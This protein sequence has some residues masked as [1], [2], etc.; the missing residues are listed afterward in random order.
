MT[1]RICRLLVVDDDKDVLRSLE[2]MLPTL[3]PE[4][5]TLRMF[6]VSDFDLVSEALDDYRVEIAIVDVKGALNEQI[7]DEHAGERVLQIIRSRR[8]IPVIFYTAVPRWVE[9]HAGPFVKVVA[10]GEIDDLRQAINDILETRLT[11]INLGLFAHIDGLQRD[12]LWKYVEQHWKEMS[13]DTELV[14]QLL[15]RRI[16]AQMSSVALGSALENAGVSNSVAESEYPSEVHPA[17]FYIVPPTYVGLMAGQLYAPAEQNPSAS[18]WTVLLTPTCD[19]VPRGGAGRAAD[20]VLLV[21]AVPPAEMQLRA[22][23]RTNL[24]R[25]NHRDRFYYLPERLELP[26]LAVD[27]ERVLIVPLADSGTWTPV[28]TLDSPFAEELQNR[29]V[30]FFGRIGTPDLDGGYLTQAEARIWPGGV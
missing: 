15:S 17:R 25:N 19:L 5:R 23:Q 1:E 6:S 30:R 2:T 9:D 28:A 18:A 26:D 24:L 22:Q 8:F 3:N 12:W 20:N 4:G 13:G 27:L 29:F 21:E 10:K 16:V 14:A 11:D 7:D